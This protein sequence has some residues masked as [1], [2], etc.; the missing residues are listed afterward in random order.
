MPIHNPGYLAESWTKLVSNWIWVAISLLVAVSF[1]LR[2]LP[3][4]QYPRVGGDPFLHYKYSIALLNGSFSVPVE[5]GSTGTMVQLYYP[6]LF[7]LVSLVLFIAFP[8]TDPYALMK[9]LASAA[10]ALVL[11]PIFFIV[12]RASGSN[13]GG[14][15]A[16]YALLATRND[17]QMLSWGGYANIAGLLLVASLLYAVMCQRV[18][19]S[20]LLSAALGLTHHLSTI[21]VIAVLVPYFAYYMWSKRR[22]HPSLTGVILGGIV[23]FLV[24]YLFAFESMIYYYS[25]FLPVYNQSLYMTPYIF[26]LVGPLLLISAPL[27]LVCVCARS[28]RNFLR[29]HAILLFWAIIPFLL[30]Y[31]YVFGVHW[32]GVRWIAFI[33]EP[34]AVWT[35]IGL[36]RLARKKYA[37]I[38]IFVLLFSLQLFCTMQGYQLDILTNIVQ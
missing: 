5:A 19:L 20:A 25:H 29:E 27:G 9:I 31:A 2:A 13:L 11:V 12:R 34:L 32:H 23:A 28:G 33:P 10:D 15:L 1:L 38:I 8:H 37:I 4:L 16:A 3:L 24:F 22:I 35:G 18:V 14:V 6:P 7:H 36:G 17:Y 21:F 26:E 30:A